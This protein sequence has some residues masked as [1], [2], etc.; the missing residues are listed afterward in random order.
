[1]SLARPQYLLAPAIAIRTPWGSLRSAAWV[2][3]AGAAI[4]VSGGLTAG[5]LVAAARA[6]PANPG[7]LRGEGPGASA[8]PTAQR[9]R[10]RGQR[11][12]RA[13]EQHGRQPS[14]DR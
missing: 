8:P 4:R 1:M 14:R 12:G 13:D 9:S 2:E 3:L 6:L 10:V 7:R 5:T 11:Q